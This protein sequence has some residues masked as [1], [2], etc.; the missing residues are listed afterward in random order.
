MFLLIDQV[1]ENDHEKKGGKSKSKSKSK[2]L[3]QNQN[4]MKKRKET[5]DGPVH[6]TY[7][8]ER[9]VPVEFVAVDIFARVMRSC[10][11]E[12]DRSGRDVDGP[13]S[14]RLAGHAVLG[15]DLDG[16]RQRSTADARLRLH[17]DRVNRVRRQVADG[18][19]R[20]VVHHLRVPRRDR[21]SRVHRVKHFVALRNSHKSKLVHRPFI[22]SYLPSLKQPNKIINGSSSSIKNNRD[23]PIVGKYVPIV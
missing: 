4:E 22:I 9:V 17:A 7:F 21:H 11:F 14:R 18:R 1:D 6:S 19:Q 13:Q 23:T 2:K 12:R 16:R 20:V 5:G 15:L 3:N 10:P 8:G